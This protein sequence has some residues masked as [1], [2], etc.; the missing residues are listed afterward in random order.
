MCQLKAHT[1][2]LLKTHLNVALN[3]ACMKC[4]E[5]RNDFINYA[6]R[7]ELPRSEQAIKQYMLFTAFANKL[8]NLI[9]FSFFLNILR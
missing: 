2:G 9:K 3:F 5:L 1:D 4:S 8:I 6:L 7:S